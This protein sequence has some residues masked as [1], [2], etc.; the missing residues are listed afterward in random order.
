MSG[1]SSRKFKLSSMMQYIVVIELA[2]VA[3][4]LQAW[5]TNS[6]YIEGASFG[7]VVSGAGL[8]FMVYR[9]QQDRAKKKLELV[10]RRG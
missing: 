5:L 6:V 4:A 3:L 8:F 2:G 10:V 1:K 9:D 7:V